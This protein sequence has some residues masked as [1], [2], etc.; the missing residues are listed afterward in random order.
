MRDGGQI[1]QAI[2][3]PRNLL[4]TFPLIIDTVT[5]PLYPFSVTVVTVSLFSYYLFA[6]CV[7]HP[8]E[9]REVCSAH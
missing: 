8:P 3:K 4:G 1:R 9:L 5:V 2:S 7:L 6:G